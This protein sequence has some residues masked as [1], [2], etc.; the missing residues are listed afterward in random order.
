MWLHWKVSNLSLSGYEP[1]RFTLSYSAIGGLGWIW[2]NNVNPE[3]PDLQS[4]DA[5][6]IAS[7]NP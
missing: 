6:A 1:D 2:T 4:G 7:T 3:G 5:H